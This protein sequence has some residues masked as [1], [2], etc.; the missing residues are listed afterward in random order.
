MKDKL[1]SC[2]NSTI[3]KAELE[4]EIAL[5]EILNNLVK[6]LPDINI[7]NVK[8]IKEFDDEGEYYKVKIFAKKK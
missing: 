8:F 6:K 7:K 4:A 2:I 5:E 3:S 1:I